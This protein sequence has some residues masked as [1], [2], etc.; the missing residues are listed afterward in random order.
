VAGVGS[1]NGES[2]ENCAETGPLPVSA[3]LQ[4]LLMGFRFE[5]PAP[6]GGCSSSLKQPGF[7]SRDIRHPRLPLPAMVAVPNA[8][9]P[10]FQTFRFDIFSALESTHRSQA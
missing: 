5:A 3:R 6:V 10:P 8:H 9:Q 1:C 2:T 7:S 4:P